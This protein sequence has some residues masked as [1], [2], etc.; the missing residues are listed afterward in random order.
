MKEMEYS[1]HGA[2]YVE[3]DKL[4]KFLRLSESGGQAHALIA[5]GAV[6]RN[7]QVEIRKRAKLR[8]GDR[9]ELPGGQVVLITGAQDG[10]ESM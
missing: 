6:L 10:A 4:L 1:L 7:G 2:P 5:S 8:P 9:I 3:L